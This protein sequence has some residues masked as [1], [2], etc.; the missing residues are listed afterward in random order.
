MQDKVSFKNLQTVFAAENGISKEGYL[1]VTLP[2]IFIEKDFGDAVDTTIT[3]KNIFVGSGA[4]QVSEENY[5]YNYIYLPFAENIKNEYPD[6]MT[7][8]K[9]LVLSPSSHPKNGVIIG[10]CQPDEDEEEEEER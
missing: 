2:D 7:G 10:R 8:D 1:K 9:F 5:S 4:P 6:V 3:N